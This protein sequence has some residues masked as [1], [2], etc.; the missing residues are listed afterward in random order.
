MHVDH[1]SCGEYV[2]GT[3]EQVR[4]LALEWFN[5]PLGKELKL[6]KLVASFDETEGE[7]PDG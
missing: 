5:L 7:T 1:R 3:G 2:S 4:R 6:S